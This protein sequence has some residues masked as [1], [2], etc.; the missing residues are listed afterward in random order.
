MRKGKD[1]DPY[2]IRIWKPQKHPDPDPQHCSY[3]YYAHAQELE[4]VQ[5]LAEEVRGFA[6]L[7][8]PL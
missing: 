6:A 8:P 5:V 1:P 3:K 7:P 2:R 4:R